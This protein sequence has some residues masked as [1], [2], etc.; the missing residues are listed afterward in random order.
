MM[1]YIV[2]YMKSLL[3]LFISLLLS[4]SS[5]AQLETNSAWFSKGLLFD[6]PTD[7]EIV[8]DDSSYFEAQKKGFHIKI[9]SFR[10]AA[11]NERTQAEATQKAAK[12]VKYDKMEKT[13]FFYL[14]TF[15][16]CAITGMK[17]N[18][19]VQVI[20]LFNQKSNLHFTAILIYAPDME[21]EISDLIRSFWRRG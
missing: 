10:N 3:F 15:K 12:Q 4:F 11:F 6:L 2:L 16:G 5:H 13:E 19:K 9:A 20:S 8:A 14:A 21:Q 1:S 7:C 18:V 17:S